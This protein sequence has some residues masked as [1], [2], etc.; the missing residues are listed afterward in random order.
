MAVPTGNADLFLRPLLLSFL[1]LSSSFVSSLELLDIDSSDFKALQVIET[2]LGVNGQRFTSNDVNPCGR[3]GVSCERRRSAATGEYVLRVTRLVY[4]SRSLT[5]AISP[6]IGRLSELKELTLSNNQLV[7]A[8]PVGILSCKQLEVLDLRN[9]RFSGQIPGNFSSLSRLRI[10][11]LSSNKFSGNLNF[12]KNLRN[13]EN[14]SVANNLFSG[15]IP[16]PVVPFHSLRFFDF[17]GNRYLEGSVPVMSN[18]IK[19]QTTPRHT[20]HI[21]AETPSSNST[22]K[23]NNSTTSKAPKGAPKPEEEK[24][25]KKKKKSKK[26]KVAAW[27]LGFVIGAIGGT[28]SGFVFSV[29]FKLI[30]AAI[31]GS[32]KP[33]GPSIFSPLIK[34]AEDLAFLEDE[35]AIAS[36]EII[37][38]GGCGEVFKAELPGSNGKLI[39]VKKVIQ[40]SKDAN[41]LADEDSKFLNKK[42]RQIRSEINTVGQIRHR[43]LLPLLAHVSRPECHFLV[44][45]YMKNGSLQ[46]I[47]T[48]VLAGQKE[49]MWPARHKIALGIAAGLEYLHMDHKPRIIHRD[50][51]PA[52]VLLDDDMEARIADFGLAKSMPD[53]ATH[54]TL[55]N[56]AGTVGYIAPEYHQTIKFTDKCDIYSFGVI[57]GVLVIGKLPSDEFFQ[58][59]DEMS[60]IKWMRNIITSENPSVAIDPTLLGQGFDEQMLL[61]LK[62]ACYCTLDDPK[63]RPNS[64]DVRTMLSQI[65][66]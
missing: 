14:L 58:H 4:R 11:D 27:I 37:G 2:E 33:S 23:P 30:V 8:V 66:H 6:V 52:N 50:L 15:K 44:Y 57:L 13:L 26:K 5:G 16:E 63:Q 24:K 46:D 31:K 48:D 51:K 55:S 53:A 64:K 43:N 39:A 61:V 47:L 17:S 41:E 54:L 25:K 10:L 45:E 60:L 62:I 12:L 18:K 65:K 1:L 20:R 9:N 40:P 34:K 22:K 42:M 32:G 19:L 59:T 21:L 49:L 35:A 38:K 56:V 7:N 36:L 3:R 28:I 29:M